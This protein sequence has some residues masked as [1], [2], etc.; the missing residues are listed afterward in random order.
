MKKNRKLIIAIDGPAGAGKSTI[1][2][3]VA[4]RLGLLYIDTGAM[5]RAVTW[6]ALQKGVDFNDLG[7][8]AAIARK[9]K[10]ELKRDDGKDALRVFADEKD[11]TGDI[12]TENVSRHSR[13]VAAVEGVRKVLVKRQREIGKKGGV[14]M[15]GRDIGTHVFPG[16]DVK[17][18]LDASPLERAKR[19]YKELKAKGVSVNLK[20]IAEDISKRD[21]QDSTRKF[22]PLRKAEGSVVIDSTG[23]TLKGV[24]DRILKAAGRT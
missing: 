18:F 12:R 5:Y 20:Q 19:R 14:V 3:M 1:S 13:I 9:I 15:E 23:L 8:I 6:K 4:K 21:H 16:A 2:R 10:I 7:K 22:S 17:I 11:I 24:A